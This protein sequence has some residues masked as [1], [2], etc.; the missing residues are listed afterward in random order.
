VDLKTKPLAL[1]GILSATGQDL[2]WAFT[3]VSKHRAGALGVTTSGHIF[4]F[5]AHK[6][7]TAGAEDMIK[8]YPVVE[9]GVLTET[10]DC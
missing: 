2:S 7:M 8:V 5:T 4:L 3:N 10:V 9:I 6:C 1:I